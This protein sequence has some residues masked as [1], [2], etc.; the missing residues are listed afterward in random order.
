MSDR[1]KFAVSVTPIE[2][3]TDENAGT[4]DIVASEVGKSLGGGGDSLAI[5]NYTGVADAQGYKDA[6][7]NY[8]SASHSAGGTALTSTQPDFVFIKNTGHKYS[9]ETVL[10]AETT[11]VV[12]V[13]IRTPAY[14][15]GAMSGWVADDAGDAV[16]DV[17]LLYPHYFE[18]AWLQPG[19]SIVLPLGCNNKSVSQFG[20]N[21]DDLSY[22]NAN[23]E[24]GAA[25]LYV[26]TVVAAGTVA[27]SANAVEFLAVT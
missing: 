12:I 4:R 3:L 2:T 14:V 19:Q 11:D 21:A 25:Q 27:A 13:A 9:S 22:I 20:S 17:G 18:I 16:S 6:A 8:R 7:V 10:G 26:K 24:T 15:N 1:I 5:A 23:L